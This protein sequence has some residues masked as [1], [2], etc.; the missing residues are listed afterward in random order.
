NSAL[1]VD[2]TTVA[3]TAEFVAGTPV[4]GGVTQFTVAAVPEPATAVMLLGGLLGLVAYAWR[5]RK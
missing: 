3:S 1:S 4:N 5:K 2:V